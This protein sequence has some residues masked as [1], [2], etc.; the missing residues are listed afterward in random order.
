MFISWKVGHPIEDSWDAAMLVAVARKVS[1]SETGCGCG[2]S[3]CVDKTEC[4]LDEMNL[5]IL[6]TYPKLKLLVAIS[7][8]AIPKVN[9]STA[10]IF[11]DAQL[12][13]DCPTINP[14][15]FDLSQTHDWT[16]IDLNGADQE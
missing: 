6:F 10:H 9:V 15:E 14:E 7:R 4:G 12:R 11:G 1:Q 2:A 13:R 8:L 16:T 3:I 5:E